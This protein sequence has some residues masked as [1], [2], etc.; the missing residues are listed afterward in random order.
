MN[1][2]L[3]SVVGAVAILAGCATVKE[4]ASDTLIAHRG[5]S[6]DAPE[7]T[8]PAYRTAVERGF[9][10]E[11][12]I[13]LAKD[14]RLFTF[15]DGT[16]TRTTAGVNTNRCTDV[17]WAGT[18]SKVNVGGWGKWKGSK[19]DP[20]RPALFSEV[21][22][23]AR[24]GRY[25]Y[26]EVKGNDPS[27]VPYIKAEIE[28][29]KNVNPGNVLFISF[30]DKLCAALK[31]A[32]P[33]YKVY[34]LMGAYRNWK[35]KRDPWSAQDVIG[36]LKA[37]HADGI[38][39]KFAPEV[40]DAAFVKAVKDAGYSF[41]VWTID[42]LEKAKKAFAVGAD[43]LTT[44]CAKKLMDEYE[45]CAAESAP[46]KGLAGPIKAVQLDLARQK[47]TVPFIEAF[48]RKVAAAGYNT[49]VLYLEGRVATD[50]FSMNPGE[51]YTADEM[52]RVVRTAADCGIEVV[53]VVSVL[54]HAEHFFTV[55][56]MAPFAE[57]RSGMCRWPVSSKQTFCL[58][59]P[60]AR[61]FLEKYVS[62]VAAIFPGKHIHLGLD[63]SFQFGF[64]DT[65]RARREKIGFGPLFTEY[66]KWADGLCH[67]LGKRMWMWDDMYEFFPEELE[68]VPRDIVMCHWIYDSDVTE[69]GHRGHFLNRIRVDWLA[70]FEKR[71]IDAIPVGAACP[72]NLRTLAAYAARH[73]TLG[74]Y[75][76][77]WELSDS[78]Y[79]P[80][81]ANLIGV[82]KAF[83]S[84]TEQER[85]AVS[86][87]SSTW[88]YFGP[89]A[90]VSLS[91]S[92]YN[93]ASAVNA[94]VSGH[95]LE[96][97]R[98]A[99]DVLKG[100][101]S[102][103]GTGKVPADPL[104]EAALLDDLVTHFEQLSFR[105]RLDEIA[106]ILFTPRRTAAESREAKARIR[107]MKPDMERVLAR[108]AEQEQAWRPNMRPNGLTTPMK[109]I[110][111]F[112]D[113]LLA[114]PDVAADDDWILGLSLSLPDFHGIPKWT[115]SGRFAD[116]WRVIAKGTW[117]PARGNWANFERTIPFKAE[118]APTALRIEHEGYGEGML[119]HV[120]AWN[121]AKRVVPKAVTHTDGLVVDPSNILRDDWRPV[122][123]GLQDRAPIFLNPDLA[124]QKSILEFTLK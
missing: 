65:C 111:A 23:L 18:V 85:L 91:R 75:V 110:L 105:Y 33:E 59:Q 107:A 50:S 86:S 116:G 14:G 55:A 35:E 19:F 9:G 52:R 53:P 41:H 10:F 74:F 96:S 58:N 103:P 100:A 17:D 102:R 89:A 32:M 36:A 94:T 13:Y 68:N 120:S 15:H 43:T 27:W 83:P 88:A 117:K 93:G 7:N 121:R 71:G 3:L 69:W 115:V 42:D 123:F 6:K 45:G 30:G 60:E 99:I 21:L 49:L 44:N 113:Q 29:A 76:S 119:L 2:K 38:D 79:G 16:L 56:K 54:G 4:P 61:A 97:I 66:V 47:E 25:I 81:I 90:G 82:E 63:E 112:A 34:Y 67:R 64:C 84:L 39:I 109:D 1:T 124:K 22:A 28:K 24:E 77:Q 122:R 48:T 101:E 104:S 57:E 51:F 118:S 70:E 62:E 31:Q 87:L 92:R 46:V 20:T 72:D 40:H 37:T 11:C 5:E 80:P 106:P 26:V 73:K 108:K 8:L 98:L 12:D 114:V 78:F 95:D